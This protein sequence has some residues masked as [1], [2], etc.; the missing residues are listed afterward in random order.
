MA[1]ASGYNHHRFSRALLKKSRKWDASLTVEFHSNNWKFQHSVGLGVKAH[2][3]NIPFR[4]RN[5][6]S[7]AMLFTYDG[8]MR[9]FLMALRSQTIPAALIPFLY[10]I[11]PPVQFVD[12][13]V[14]V[15]VHDKRRTPETMTRIVMRPAP[16]AL[17][18]TIDCMMERRGISAE[19]ER[20]SQEIEA[21]ILVS[22]LQS[23]HRYRG[24]GG[25]STNEQA[26]VEWVTD[27]MCLGS[28][29]VRQLTLSLG[30]LHP[31]TSAHP[32]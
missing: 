27:E 26:C 23:S 16:L 19:D 5:A 25:S 17:T 18:Q 32:Y 1:S 8:P 11:Q 9:P 6:D 10:D 21:R 14:V 3:V 12:G 13:C 24:S 31:C 20:F 2:P 28:G 22:H 29:V 7:Q 30:H 15:E 4:W